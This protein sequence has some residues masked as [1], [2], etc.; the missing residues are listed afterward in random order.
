[1]GRAT[2]FGQTEENTK[3]SMLKVRNKVTENLF[4]EMGEYT[5]VSGKMASR[6]VE[7][8]LYQKI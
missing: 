6:M 3:E 8:F 2:L 5:K 4:G 7:G 1:M